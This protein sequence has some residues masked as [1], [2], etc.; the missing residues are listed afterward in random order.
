M[1]GKAGRAETVSALPPDNSGGLVFWVLASVHGMKWFMCE[2]WFYAVIFLLISLAAWAFFGGAAYRAAALHAAREEKI[3]I[4]QAL[5]FSAGKFLSF[6]MAPLMPIAGIL[7]LG[8]LLIIG[9]MLGNIWGFGA[10]LVGALF[11]LAILLGLC[12]A[13]AAIGLIT[14]VGLMYPTIAV[15]GSDGFDALSRSF[16]YVFSKPWRAVLYGVLALVYGA[17][18]YVFVRFFAYLALASTHFFVKVGVWAGG[19]RLAEGADKLDAMWAAPTFT[20]FHAPST[21]EAMSTC[22]QIGSFVISIWVYL[23]IGMVLAFVLSYGASVTTVIYYLM[24]RKVD[25]TD[26]D[27]V[28]V[29]EAEEELPAPEA[30]QAAAEQAGAPEPP[31]A[32]EGQGTEEKKE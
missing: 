28:Y 24:R 19:E 16:S 30:G 13:F 29:E 32:Q 25:A 26:L 1:D 3:S 21:W 2:F 31:E 6:F 14:G 8:A 23:V 27:D 22:E 17:L 20:V 18:C 5:R 9:G 15:E 12:I 4:S 11:F 10:I 7:V